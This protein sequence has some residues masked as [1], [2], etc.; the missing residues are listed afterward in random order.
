MEVKRAASKWLKTNGGEFANF[1]WQAGYGAFS[2]GQSG[3]AETTAYIAD[4]ERP[5]RRKNLEEELRALL[6]LS[7]SNLMNVS[8]GID[9]SSS[10]L[11]RAACL[12]ND[13]PGRCPGLISFAPLARKAKRSPATNLNVETLATG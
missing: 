10:A 4:Q 8:C 7:N 6:K 9:C 5:L 11:K 1:H 12:C 2:I 13:F 3:V